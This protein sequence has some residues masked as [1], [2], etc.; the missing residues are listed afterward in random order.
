[1]SADSL[2]RAIIP[3]PMDAWVPGRPIIVPLTLGRARLI[4]PTSPYSWDRGW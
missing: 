3:D 1:M 2:G 4:V